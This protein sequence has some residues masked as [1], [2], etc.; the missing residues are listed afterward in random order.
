MNNRTR[1]TVGI[2]TVLE[3]VEP[4]G[5]SWTSSGGEARLEKA[6]IGKQLRK[7]TDSFRIR[8]IV[9]SVSKWE[10]NWEGRAWSKSWMGRWCGLA[11]WLPFRWRV[12]IAELGVLHYIA[13]RDGVSSSTDYYLAFRLLL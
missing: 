11:V 13:L 4:R 12:V 3:A 9:K 7:S 2:T 6:T 8:I 10:D 1:I 5:K